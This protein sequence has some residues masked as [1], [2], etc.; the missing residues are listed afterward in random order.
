D[1]DRQGDPHDAMKALTA[2]DP[3]TD[4]TWVLGYVAPDD[5]PSKLMEQVVDS[6]T[7][8]HHVVIHAWN[9]NS[10][11]EA[12]LPDVKQAQRS[13]RVTAHR[14]HKQTVVLLHGLA[15]TLGAIAESDPAWIQHPTY[16]HKQNTFS[17]RNRELMQIAVDD[18]LGGGTD[19]TAAKKLLETI[20]KTNWGGWVVADHDDVVSR[21]RNVVDSGR[22]GKVAAD[23]PPPVYEGYNRNRQIRQRAAQEIAQPPDP[24]KPP[25]PPKPNQTLKDALLELD[26]LLTAYPGNAS[27]HILKCELLIIQPGIADAKTRTACHHV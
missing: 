16:S 23:I 13:E 25:P 7:L 26:N 9:D 17:D 1:W 27:M 5:K 24:K 14:R 6:T 19:M 15:T 2:L 11:I 21:F 3:G 20:E 4:A 18:R 10:E 8:G 22:A 12:K